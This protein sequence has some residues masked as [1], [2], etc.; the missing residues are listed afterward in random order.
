MFETTGVGDADLY[1][2]LGAEP[3]QST[4]DCQSHRGDSDEFCTFTSPAAGDYFVM[5]RAFSSYSALTLV[6]Q[7]P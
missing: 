1:V 3:S 2:K 5:V 6:G 7:F 4:F